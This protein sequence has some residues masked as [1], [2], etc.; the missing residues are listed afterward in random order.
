MDLLIPPNCTARVNIPEGVNDYQLNGTLFTN[1]TFTEV[2]SG[3]Y[4]FQWTLK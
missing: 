2:E 4:N 3:E 1:E